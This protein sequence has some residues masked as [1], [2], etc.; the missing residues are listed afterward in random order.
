MRPLLFGPSYSVYVAIAKIVLAEKGVD[1]D[2]VEFDVFD[3]TRWPADWLQRHPFGQVPAFEHDGFCL[4]ETRAITRYIDEAFE[5]PGLQPD[6][7][8]GRARMEQAISVLDGQGYRPMV[9]GVYVERV[10]RGKTGE[11]DE[12]AIAAALPKAE[13]CLGALAALLGE[14]AFFGG[15]N[16][17][18]AD[19]QAAPMFDYFVRAAEGKDL[20]PAQPTLQDWWERVS[21]R[22]SVRRACGG[23]AR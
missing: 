4:Y 20:M 23:E 5:G 17:S 16:F 22:D 2:Q 15:K 3:R 8:R 6:D 14:R 13:R 7:A 21:S 18:L 9:W 11:S 12:A 19:A 10:S 1:Y